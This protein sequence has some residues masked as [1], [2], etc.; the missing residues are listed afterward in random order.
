MHYLLLLS[1]GRLLTVSVQMNANKYYGSQGTMSSAGSL[2]IV[3][4]IWSSLAEL[5]VA[6]AQSMTAS[7][8]PSH[9]TSN[10]QQSL[11]LLLNIHKVQV[12]ATDT[13]VH[14]PECVKI[15][16]NFYS[17]K[18]YEKFSGEGNSPLTRSIPQWGW[19]YPLSTP[20]PPRRLRLL[21][22]SLSKILGTP[23]QVLLPFIRGTNDANFFAYDL[24]STRVRMRQN[25]F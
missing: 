12:V 1:P 3:L 8:R 16:F 9:P 20:Q 21:D 11:L 17:D 24:R 6:E 25:M 4:R 22:S 7:S 15:C 14:V 5:P 13:A 23:L 10:Q 18:I 2:K 19:G